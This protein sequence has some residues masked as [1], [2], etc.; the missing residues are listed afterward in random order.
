MI[1]IAILFQLVSGQ[2][3]LRRG[4]YDDTLCRSNFVVGISSAQPGTCQQTTPL[5]DICTV[6][7]QDVSKVGD[8]RSAET[9]GCMIPGP[10]GFND[11]PWI[12]GPDEGNLI[13]S[14]Y[15]FINSYSDQGCPAQS[16]NEQNMFVANGN[17][18]AVEWENSFFKASC[19]DSAAALDICNDP[20]CTDCDGASLEAGILQDVSLSAP[21]DQCTTAGGLPFKVSCINPLTIQAQAEGRPVPSNTPADGSSNQESRAVPTLLFSVAM[22]L[23]V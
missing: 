3:W 23:F 9:A 19:N 10:N 1:E 17:C 16:I 8:L 20:A 12:P 11:S 7:A 2:Q 21:V 14:D 6:K 18:Y 15:M 4:Y 5:I 22:F 13:D